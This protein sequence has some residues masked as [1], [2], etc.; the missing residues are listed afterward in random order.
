MKIIA[1]RSFISTKQ[2]VG[3]VPE[4]R[5]L[6]VDDAYAE[7]LIRAGLAEKFSADPALRAMRTSFFLTPGTATG[8]GPLSPAA[9]ALPQPIVK[10]SKR[11]AKK[12]KQDT[13]L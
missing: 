3:N 4:G 8:S 6:N 12:G 10:R 1:K 11:G 5:V 13:S 9:P 7:S 2:G